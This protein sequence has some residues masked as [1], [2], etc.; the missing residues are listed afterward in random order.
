MLKRRF[1][2]PGL[3]FGCVVM[4]ALRLLKTLLTRDVCPEMRLARVPAEALGRFRRG[5]VVEEGG[6]AGDGAPSCQQGHL[7]ASSLV[8][9]GCRARQNGLMNRTSKV[10]THVFC[11]F[12]LFCLFVQQNFCFA[13][14]LSCRQGLLTAD[15]HEKNSFGS[16]KDFV[17]KQFACF[18]LSL[19]Y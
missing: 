6:P 14:P 13:L 9:T 18:A 3:T 7:Q 5:R 1:G 15:I 16:T 11:G 8:C 19:L 10:S 17:W 4:E 12:G 2:S